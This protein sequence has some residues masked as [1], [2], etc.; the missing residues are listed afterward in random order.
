M[1][2]QKMVLFHSAKGF[3]V[4]VYQDLGVSTPI[5]LVASVKGVHCLGVLGFR[6]TCTRIFD[7]FHKGFHCLGVSG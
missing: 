4:W 1:Y 3:V 6:N 5:S 7:R 2:L